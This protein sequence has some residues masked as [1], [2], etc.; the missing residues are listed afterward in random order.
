MSSHLVVLQ[1]VNY[2]EVIYEFSSG[3]LT[4]CKL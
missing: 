2:E 1:Y 4:E 3:R